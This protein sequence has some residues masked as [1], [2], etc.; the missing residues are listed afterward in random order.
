MTLEDFGLGLLNDSNMAAEATAMG[1]TPQNPTEKGK[2]HMEKYEQVR[3]CRMAST[4][5]GPF[6][7]LMDFMVWCERRL[8]GFQGSPKRNLATALHPW[9]SA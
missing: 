7:L 4:P 2:G 5:T 1:N 8:P 9:D 6:P 3:I